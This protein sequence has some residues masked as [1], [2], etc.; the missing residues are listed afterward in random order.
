MR[1]IWCN[2]LVYERFYEK[3]FGID[4]TRA[5]DLRPPD[6]PM[7]RIG[8]QLKAARVHASL[9]QRHVE[10]LTGIDQTTISRLENG[11]GGA[12]PLDRFA[13]LL[14]AIDAE[15]RPV[16]RSMPAWLEPLIVLDDDGSDGDGLTPDDDVGEPADAGEHRPGTPAGESTLGG[17]DAR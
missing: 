14:Q 6:H 4:P 13:R 1:P 10:E 15:I 16:D 3:W 5:R 17:A 8:A 2:G 11:K 9:T 12:M 7:V